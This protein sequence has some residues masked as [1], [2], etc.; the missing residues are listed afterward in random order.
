MSVS[1]TGMKSNGKVQPNR[2]REWRLASGLSLDEVADLVGLSVSMVSRLERGER[3]LSPQLRV[4]FARRL[5]VPV[6]E[7]FTVEPLAEKAG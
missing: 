7:I 2:I 6:R 4:T 3:R 5:G 1:K